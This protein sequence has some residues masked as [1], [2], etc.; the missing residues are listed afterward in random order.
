M[1]DQELVLVDLAHFSGFYRVTPPE[2]GD[3]DHIVFN[4][5][6]RT[7][8]GRIFQYLRMSNDE[9]RSLETAARQTAAHSGLAPEF[10]EG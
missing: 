10:L 5:G 8:Y 2:S 7:L 4:E 3:R 9:I 6:M 1:E